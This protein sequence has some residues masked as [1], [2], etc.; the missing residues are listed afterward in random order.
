MSPTKYLGMRLS[1]EVVDK[2][3]VLQEANDWTPGQVVAQTMN[4]HERMSSAIGPFRIGR[5][6]DGLDENEFVYL[7]D[8]ISNSNVMLEGEQAMLVLVWLLKELAEPVQLAFQEPFD[9]SEIL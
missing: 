3:E 1:P 4:F 9:F 6:I 7:R 2:L 8:S 5:F